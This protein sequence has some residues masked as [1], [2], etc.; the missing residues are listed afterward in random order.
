MEEE[1]WIEFLGICTYV[2]AL[3]RYVLV[4]AT[5]PNP[6]NERYQLTGRDSIVPH[7]ALLT[8]AKDQ[9]VNIE[10]NAPFQDLPGQDVV[11]LILDG[12]T[13]TIANAAP[14]IVGED[15]NCLPHLSALVPGIGPGPA[16]ND[17]NPALASCYFD[18]DSGI[19]RGF[20]T[21]SQAGFTRFFTQTSGDPELRI[22]PFGGGSSTLVTLRNL[23]EGRPITITNLPT[24]QDEGKDNDNDFLLQ[25]LAAD[26]FPSQWPMPLP[27]PQCPPSNPGPI[28]PPEGDIGP[29]CSNSNLP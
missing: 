10:G 20:Q 4:N 1:A 14:S 13:L 27:L 24:G 6:I 22:T 7:V 3:S 12:Y 23:A 15:A 25:F 29:G 17:G 26:Q 11:Q 28:N 2:P 19:I 8:I 18:F 9:I 21:P 16:V 5:N